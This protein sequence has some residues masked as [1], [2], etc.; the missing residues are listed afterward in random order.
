MNSQ[1]YFGSGLSPVLKIKKAKTSP[2]SK[3]Q[4]ETY[5]KIFTTLELSGQ[6]KSEIQKN[7][8]RINDIV[9]KSSDI[10]V[11]ISLAQTQANKIFDEYKAINR[12]L[13][14]KE[15]GHEHLFEVFFER[16]FKLGSVGLQE[17]RE[18]KL[19]K[20]GL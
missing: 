4:F 18:Y 8:K 12:A 16:A 15:L 11:Q 20:L 2:R 14:A 13:V 5:L 17:Y 1:I 9:A 10:N 6:S 7:Y 3:Y 19:S